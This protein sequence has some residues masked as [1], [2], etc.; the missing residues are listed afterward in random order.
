MSRNIDRRTIIKGAGIAG[1]AGLAGCTGGPSDGN[2][3]NGDDGNGNGGNGNGDDGNG[4]GDDGNGNG[5]DGNGNGDD[6]DTNI[7]MVYAEAGLGDNSFN[8]AAQRGLLAADEDFNIEYNEVEPNDTGE[9]SQFQRQFSE[10]GSYDLITC[11]GF[12]QQDALTETSADY[13]DQQFMI[14]DAVVEDA[15]NV[16]NYLFR[17]NEGSFLVGYLAAQLTQTDLTVGSGDGER[18]TNTDESLVG[19]VGGVDAPLIRTFQ[20]GFEAGVAYAD[21]DVESTSTYTGSFNDPSAGREAALSMY[22]DGADIVYHASGGTGVGVF[23]AADDEGRFAIGVDSDQSLT[24][25]DFADVILASMVKL[26]ETPV[27]ESIQNTIE[28][29]F[30]GG[31]AVTLGLEQEGVGVVYGD[32]LGDEISQDVKDAVATARQEIIDGEIEVPTEP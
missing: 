25:P 15:D 2:G 9:F 22:D 30:Q 1:I 6:I 13:P 32:E 31:S 21:G 7:G 19:F 12:A 27:Y 14:V 5:D 29:D 8:D 16:A 18:S 10:D 11:I 24:E 20:A 17:E 4:N 28:G 26:V 23:Q 3:G